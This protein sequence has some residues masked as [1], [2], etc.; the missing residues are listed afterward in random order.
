MNFDFRKHLCVSQSKDKIVSLTN[1]GAYKKPVFHKEA[2]PAILVIV[3]IV[4]AVF[5]IVADVL[6]HGHPPLVTQVQHVPSLLLPPLSPPVRSSMPYGDVTKPVSDLPVGCPDA[7]SVKVWCKL[8]A[9]GLVVN[10]NLLVDPVNFLQVVSVIRVEQSERDLT[11]TLHKK[12]FFKSS[13][14]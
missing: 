2:I 14:E 6:P 12:I 9:S 10:L 3:G 5:E 11:R 7:K 4:C 8:Y 13:V 1:Q